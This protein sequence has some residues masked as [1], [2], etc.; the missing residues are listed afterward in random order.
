MTILRRIRIL[1]IV[2]DKFLLPNKDKC[3]FRAA[4][5]NGAVQLKL[6]QLFL[7]T[8]IGNYFLN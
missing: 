7:Q 6:E 4:Y 8:N 1:Q 2:F 3:L 5:Y